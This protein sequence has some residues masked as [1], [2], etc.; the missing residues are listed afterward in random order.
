MLAGDG[1]YGF[2]VVGESH[3]QD[4]LS[5]ICGGPCE[6]GHEFYCVATLRPEPSNPHD[7]NAVAVDVEGRHVA[8]LARED[9]VDFLSEV[10]RLGVVGRRIECDAVINGGWDRGERGAGHFG[11]EL[12]L[13]W[14]LE[15]A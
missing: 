10:R 15:L 13:V 8:Y 14:P 6:E 3:R 1:E 7:R 11:V 4:A 2:E 9:A 12:D 5:A